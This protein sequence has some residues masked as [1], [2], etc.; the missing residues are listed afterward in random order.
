MQLLLPALRIHASYVAPIS[1]CLSQCLCIAHLAVFVSSAIWYFII[2]HWRKQTDDI[3][4]V[5]YASGHLVVVTSHSWAYL[6][7]RQSFRK[8]K[9][10]R[11]MKNRLVLFS[12]VIFFFLKTYLFNLSSSN[13][14]G[15]GCN[16]TSVNAGS[17]RY[18]LSTMLKRIWKGK[19]SIHVLT[20]V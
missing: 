3:V 1:L 15:S 14:I 11:K 7:P 18:V 4:F 16:A 17:I 20:A 19:Q 2:G 12:F 6:F 10:M 9:T 5:I 13:L 8:E